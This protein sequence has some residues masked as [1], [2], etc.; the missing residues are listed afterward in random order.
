LAAPLDVNY[1]FGEERKGGRIIMTENEKQY[2]WTSVD[3]T[4]DSRGW[5]DY[6]DTARALEFFEA[7]KRESYTMLVLEEGGSVLDVGCGTGDDVLALAEIVGSNGWAVGIDNSEVMIAE[8]RKRAKGTDLPVEFWVGDAHSLDFA[9]NT[10]DGCRAERVFQHLEEPVRALAEIVRV[11]RPGARIVVGEPDWETL[12]VDAPDK[13]LTRK[14]LNHN[15]DSVRNGWC[16]RQL[17]RFF[18]EAGLTDIFVVPRTMV[19]TDF[20]LADRFFEF[21]SAAKELEKAGGLTTGQVSEWLNWLEEANQ[22][23][24]F[25]CAVVGFFVSGRKP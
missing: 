5:V 21:R 6:L 4:A 24:H 15:C 20:G 13:A 22:A 9:D 11:A 2:G 14:V 10:F 19:L 1:H 3:H 16:G 8:A 12:I 18:K 7:I 23:G 17:L 25:F